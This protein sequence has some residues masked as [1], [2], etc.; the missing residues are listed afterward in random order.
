MRKIISS[1]DSRGKKFKKFVIGMSMGGDDKPEEPAGP[2]PEELLQSAQ[3]ECEQL[4]KEAQ[5][6]A[7]LTCDEACKKGYEE[8][9]QKGYEEAKAEL[10]ELIV[11]F[12]NFEDELRRQK[13]EA[14]KLAEKELVE[15]ALA[16]AK[17]VVRYE[18]DHTKQTVIRAISE[19][20]PQLADK[21]EILI[22][23]NPEDLK[24]VQECAQDVKSAEPAIVKLDI[25]PD[26]RVSKGGAIVQSSSGSVDTDIDILIET[27][28]KDLRELMPRVEI[29]ESVQDMEVD[30]KKEGEQSVVET[31]TEDE[32]DDA[33]KEQDASEE[34]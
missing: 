17:K 1:D 29:D 12:K 3:E 34:L 23:V 18:V 31:G 9:F 8:G 11:S 6:Q 33:M 7:K 30:D 32:A 28:E 19:S 10:I 16:I 15:L 25:A 5:E 27:L 24:V 26:D 14:L 21:E 4:K 22:R 13:I 2:S 20:I